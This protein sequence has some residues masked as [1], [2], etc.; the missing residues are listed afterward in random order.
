NGDALGYWTLAQNL[1]HHRTFSLSI[2]YPF[3][4]ETVRTPGY[5]LFLTPFAALFSSP[6][7]PVAFV[8]CLLGVAT[9]IIFYQWLKDWAGKKGAAIGACVLSF[10]PVTLLHTP[11][12]MT[13]TLYNLLLVLA[14]ICTWNAC[15]KDLSKK[16]KSLAEPAMAGL[17]WALAAFV[18][19]ISIYLPL[20]L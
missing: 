1:L 10:D 4:A 8:Q 15:D 9:T 16:H 20:I 3:I 12:I 14:M 11:L 17:F 2:A 13:E 7:F 19:P 18:R 6:L 5:P